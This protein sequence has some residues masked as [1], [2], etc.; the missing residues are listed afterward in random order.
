[1]SREPWSSDSAQMKTNEIMMN[2]TVDYHVLSYFDKIFIYP[3]CGQVGPYCTF[4][5]DFVH[6][7]VNIDEFLFKFLAC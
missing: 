1:M 4:R 6:F 7:F 2:A 5:G 3:C